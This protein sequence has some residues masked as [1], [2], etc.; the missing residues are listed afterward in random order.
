MAVYTDPRF[1][2]SEWRLVEKRVDNAYE[3]SGLG[4]GLIMI[5]AVALALVL[6]GAVRGLG[7]PTTPTTTVADRSFEQ[8]APMT[9][10]KPVPRIPVPQ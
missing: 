10:L 1:S 2:D 4:P 8:P 5:F 7:H 6:F 3:K 9:P